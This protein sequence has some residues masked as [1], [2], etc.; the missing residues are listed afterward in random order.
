MAPDTT[1]PD[2]AP[3]VR[4]HPHGSGWWGMMML[5]ATEAAL[6]VYLLF[7][8]YYIAAQIPSPWPPAGQLDA[9][10]SLLNTVI[11]LSS[12]FTLV[13]A[14]RAAVRCETPVAWLGVTILLGTIF[15]GIQAFEW[16][17]KP[18]TPASDSFGSLYFVITGFHMAHVVV[19][20]LMLGSVL[21]W[22]WPGDRPAQP[23]PIR[24]A[25]YY[26]HFVDAVWLAVFFS[27]FI[28]PAL[29]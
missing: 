10:L 5:I 26:W 12:S 16:T 15:V 21:S 7:S 27:L 29:V 25:G 3:S 28:F 20:L 4:A 13:R 14:E 8:Y 9:S 1:Q 24:L 17:N 11:L 19:G 6:F 23:L 2:L 18:F 22:Q